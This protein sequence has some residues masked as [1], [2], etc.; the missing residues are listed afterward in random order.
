MSIATRTCGKAVVCVVASCAVGS[1]WSQ[2]LPPS[3]FPLD[4]GNLWVFRFRGFEDF[5]PELQDIDL[6]R[7][8]VL[9]R[10]GPICELR[11]EHEQ[12]GRILSTRSVVVRDA[13]G[14]VDILGQDVEN[15]CRAEAPRPDEFV[16]HYRFGVESFVHRAW[17][18]CRD[19][20]VL[21]EVPIDLME[22]PAERSAIVL[23]SFFHPHAV[24]TSFGAP[25]PGAVVSVS[26]SLAITKAAR[27]PGAL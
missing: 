7:I 1:A 17:H 6:W 21:S 3:G 18:S 11:Y 8:E 14:E 2:E 19:G 4:S 13:G 22:I 15:S 24:S 26:S 5:E 25:R 23:N 16:P 20:L 10:V 12:F 27:Q 9:S